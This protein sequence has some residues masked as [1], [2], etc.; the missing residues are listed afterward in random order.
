[1]N[2][3]ILIIILTFINITSILLAYTIVYKQKNYS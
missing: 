3:Y 2:K 1:M